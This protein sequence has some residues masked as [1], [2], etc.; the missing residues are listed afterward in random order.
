VQKAN[1]R[2]IPQIIEVALAHDINTISFLAV[3]VSNPFAFGDRELITPDDGLSL[4][5]IHELER[6][7]ESIAEHYADEIAAGKLAES[8]EKLRR[9]LAQYFKALIG[10]AK[11]PRP[12]CN[13]PHFST[14]V[15]VDGRLRPCY[16]LPTYGRL[17]PDGER[18]PDAIN[19]QVAQ[20]LR[21][22]YRTGQRA[23]CEKCVCPLY[24]SPRGLLRM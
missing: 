6:I 18:L 8:P 23:E 15:E 20:D 14:V 7:I 19:W 22:A 16:F 17:R 21:H 5:E 4:D 2:E 12:P 9:I 10:E 3:D 13:A 1:F 24:K 11:F